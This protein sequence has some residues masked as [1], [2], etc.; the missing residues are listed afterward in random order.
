MNLKELKKRCIDCL[1]DDRRFSVYDSD[2]FETESRKE[3]AK[4]LLEIL[5][6]LEDA[7]DRLKWYANEEN[8]TQSPY[9]SC[10]AEACSD[11]GYLASIHFEKWPEDE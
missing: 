1:N 3:E 10:D 11:R 6:R 4:A 5:E 2:S 9:S 8:Y 7:R